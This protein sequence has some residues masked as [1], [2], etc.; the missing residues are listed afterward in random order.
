ML[1]KLRDKKF[2]KKI[3]IALAIIIVPAFVFWG[4]GGAMRNRK[5][6][7]YVGKLFGRNIPR[8][9]YD[10]AMQAV[11][12]YAI[13]QYQNNFSEVR[14]FLDFEA[15]AIDRILL[16]EEAKKRKIR[17]SDAEVIERIRQYAMFHRKGAFDNYI[18]NSMLRDYF[19]TP[20]RVFEEQV[21]QN[22]ILARLFTE[23]TKD[24]T[25]SEDEI[26]QGYE[27]ENIQVDLSYIASLFSE[28]ENE[29]SVSEEQ[30][31]EYFDKNPLEFKQPV[32]FNLEYISLTSEN[33][34]EINEKIGGLMRRVR[35]KADFRE[36]AKEYGLE[37]KETGLFAQT[38][39]IPDIGW[40]P[41]ILN[42]LFK[43]KPGEYL[44]PMRIDKSFYVFRIK[45]RKNPYVPKF[46]D[47]KEKVQQTY[48]KTKS[49]ELAKKRI[50][51]CLEKLQK[52]QQK[53]AKDINFDK[54]AK[55]CALKSG[56]TG[57]FKYGSYIKDIGASDIFWLTARN[58]KD[59]LF[60]QI[61]ET[62]TGYYIIKVKSE[63]D[64]D[65][66]KFEEEKKVF[67]EKLLSE[68]KA[69]YF[70]AFLA[71]YKRKLQLQ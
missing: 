39:P 16:L 51:A 14:K 59:K 60:S 58:L 46:Q 48:L 6:T 56:S 1:K 55:A 52:S 26:R 4:F 37:V 8:Q 10:D 70:N 35:K 67:S 5:A 2:A 33:E 69:E 24:V 54:T 27:K 28:A 44:L 34:N 21:R 65:E 25:L 18:Y 7:P 57:E 32:S 66:K 12:N 50:D 38:D 45:E 42:Y 49:R 36:S 71:E 40:V 22:L 62:P 29:I 17:I 3:W 47:I 9:E 68:K 41:Q 20:P 23:A 63:A 19:K 64:F 15:E 11:K 53:G 13:L 61:I 31:K 30:L 43:A